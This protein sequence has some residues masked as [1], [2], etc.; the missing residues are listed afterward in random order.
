MCCGLSRADYSDQIRVIRIGVAVDNEQNAKTAGD[1]ADAMPAF[2]TVLEPVENDGVHGVGED[3]F[4]ERE[5]QAV[6][7]AVS[8]LL[9]GI[10]GEPHG[11]SF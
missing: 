4:G 7:A 6:L 1:R 8:G 11:G 3:G 5:I 2:L 10:S 9:A